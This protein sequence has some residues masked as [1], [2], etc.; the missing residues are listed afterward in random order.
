MGARRGLLHVASLP[1]LS[2]GGTLPRS[3]Q[4]C[5]CARTSRALGPRNSLRIG[6]PASGPRTERAQ[7]GAV[8]PH[9]VW[10]THWKREEEHILYL[11]VMLG[12]FLQLKN[13]RY[14]VRPFTPFHTFQTG[15][16]EPSHE[17]PERA[18]PH[19]FGGACF[20]LLPEIREPKAGPDKGEVCPSTRWVIT[21]F[22]KIP[23]PLFARGNLKSI[24]IVRP[25]GSLK[26]LPL[27]SLGLGV[28]PGAPGW[29]GIHGAPKQRGVPSSP[30]RMYLSAHA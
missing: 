9:S 25:F 12:L 1:G 15:Q 4:T 11:W 7:V 29:W 2:P 17:A 14:P 6:A 5:S 30:R 23:T 20:A 13:E 16:A 18:Y 27:V 3:P 22:K 8:V 10:C 26:P 21:P 24:P 28:F 19:P